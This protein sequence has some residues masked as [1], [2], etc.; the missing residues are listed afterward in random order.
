MMEV[1]AP[2]SGKLHKIILDTG[3]DVNHSTPI[4]II[5]QGISSINKQGRK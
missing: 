3:D 5:K 1:I 4:G 2:V